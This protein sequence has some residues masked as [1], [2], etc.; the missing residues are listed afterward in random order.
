M[1]IEEFNQQVEKHYRHNFL[2]NML[3][4]SLFWLGYNFFAPSQI[5]P[6]YASYFTQN[7]F[8]IGLIASLGS[9]GYLVP[10]LFTSNRVQRM[11]VKKRMVVNIGFFLERLPVILLPLSAFFFAPASPV[12]A[13]ISLY[14]L[15]SWHSLGAGTI[16][17]AWQDMVAKVIPVNRR[18]RFFGV[19]NFIG[20]GTGVVG[21]AGAAWMLASYPFPMGYVLCFA[22]AALFIFLSWVAIAQTREPALLTQEQPR[23]Q[24][25]F[26]RQ[27]PGVIRR[28]ANFARYLATAAT[29]TFS[30]LGVG[31]LMVYAV[32]RWELPDSLAGVFT[33]VMLIGQSLANLVYGAL[34]DR[35]GHKLVM[36]ISVLAGTLSFV[37]AAAAPEWSWFYVVFALRGVYLAGSL[38]SGIAIALEFSAPDMRPTYIGLNSTFSGVAAVLAPLVGS[39]LA[40]QLGFQALFFIGSAIGLCGL[41][42]LRWLVREPRFHQAAA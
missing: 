37:L 13:L 20:T 30:N 25:D 3:D 33:S 10:Q 28:D 34:A 9:I 15:F 8:L 39:L 14:A 31:F 32:R 27:L 5:L 22:L 24:I 40:D 29:I 6:L 36:E 16:A 21:A 12:L 17:V 26:F 35:K 19:T 41:G 7:T 4:G 2:Y 42:M 1:G 11:P 38:L 18:G 23:S